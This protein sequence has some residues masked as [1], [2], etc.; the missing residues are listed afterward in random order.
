MEI[1]LIGYGKMG[2]LIDEVAR[3]QGHDVVARFTSEKPFS[4]SEAPGRDLGDGVVLI[5]FTAPD[6][7]AATVCEAANLGRPIVVGTTS[8]H[9]KIDEVRAR[10]E[11]GGIGLVHASNFALGTNLFYHIA[12]HAARLLASSRAST[13]TSKRPTTVSSSTVLRTRRW[14]CGTF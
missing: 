12:E 3:S 8:W 13:P 6:A 9:E 14:C 5:D 4:A 2:S 10:V 11:E 1:A 7:V